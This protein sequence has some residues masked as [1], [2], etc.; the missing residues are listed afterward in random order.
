MQTCEH[1][2][3]REI[4]HMPSGPPDYITGARHYLPGDVM[5]LRCPRG[6]P[7]VEITIGKEEDEEL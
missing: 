3:D 5:I 6:C 4:V 2:L 7:D 1:Q